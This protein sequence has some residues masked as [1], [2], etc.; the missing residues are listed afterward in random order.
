MHLDGPGSVV[1][2]PGA[3]AGSWG[4]SGV[5]GAVL[6]VPVAV[7]GATVAIGGRGG[8]RGWVLET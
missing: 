5:L 1:L 2:G 3:G 6:W 4:W 8:V 7:L